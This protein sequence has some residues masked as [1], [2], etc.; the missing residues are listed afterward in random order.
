VTVTNTL[1]TTNS[2]KV[3]ISNELTAQNILSGVNTAILAGGQAV[4]TGSIS[5]NVLTVTAVTSGKLLPGH[6]LSGTGVTSGTAISSYGTGTGGVGTYYVTTNA[7]IFSGYIVGTTLTVTS[8]T[9]G[10]LAANQYLYGYG[11][12]AGTTIASLGTGSGGTGT[13]TISSSQ[14][15]AGTFTFSTS[16]TQTASSTTITASAWVAHDTIGTYGGAGSV[17][18]A[19]TTSTYS[20]MITYVYKAYCAD[21]INY[22]YFILRWDIIKQ[23]FWTSCAESWNASTHIGSNESWSQAG[24]FEQGYDIKDC[25]IF[26]AAHIRHIVLWPFIKNEPGLWTGVF[27]MERSAYEDIISDNVPCFAWTNSLMI[28]TPYGNPSNNGYEATTGATVTNKYPSNVMFAFPR[29]VDGYTGAGAARWCAPTTQRGMFPPSYPN[30]VNA[31]GTTSLGVQSTTPVIGD[32]NL[33]HLGSYF[34]FVYGWDTSS[35]KAFVTPV[36]VDRID[37][38][39]QFGRMFNVGVTKPLGGALDTTMINVNNSGGW[40]DSSGASTECVLL[41]MNGGPEL[42][43]QTIGSGKL[44]SPV[45]SGAVSASTTYSSPSSGVVIGD[46]IFVCNSE[47]VFVW[48]VTTQGAGVAPTKIYPS[49]S[50]NA[51]FNLAYDG[52][53]YIYGTLSNGLVRIKVDDQTFSTLTTLTNGGANLSLDATNIYVSSR[54]TS[55]TPN[56]YVVNR[57]TFSLTATNTLGTAESV[58]TR[59]GTPVSDYNGNVYVSIIGNATSTTTAFAICVFSAST[60]T[61]SIRTV[62]STYTNWPGGQVR[63]QFWIDPTSGRIFL[64]ALSHNSATNNTAQGLYATNAPFSFFIHALEY[65]SGL[66]SVIATSNFTLVTFT[67]TMTAATSVAWANYSS[68]DNNLASYNG[69]GALRITTFRGLHC[70]WIEASA[71]GNPLYQVYGSTTVL[72]SIISPQVVNS[73]GIYGNFNGQNL[74]VSRGLAISLSS[75]NTSIVFGYPYD[76]TYYGSSWFY[77]NGPRVFWAISDLNSRK[78]QYQ[79]GAYTL[80]NTRGGST[81]RLT[82][83]G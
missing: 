33:N 60:G 31:S 72:F 81:G 52:E 27:E 67:N 65:S 68:G 50:T 78:I 21:A 8:V 28:G 44:Q 38:N 15:T 3:N 66:S 12:A 56:C 83:L 10:T 34:N 53:N 43:D 73:S 80:T 51:V 49:G 18:G 14:T 55:T 82:L 30:Y 9:S 17:P 13:Y 45:T 36:S 1:Y 48:N 64:I 16:T 58:V 74:N 59:Y 70:L 6:V 77:T 39:G 32:T 79:T 11:I 29:T 19:G 24:A 40:P 54:T 22:K 71:L 26:V 25:F 35:S 23:R 61:Q 20:P 41:P 63:S 76:G 7:A 62:P 47:G 42:M 69:L 46:N 75:Y 4:V 5:G 57:S 37:R 2:Y